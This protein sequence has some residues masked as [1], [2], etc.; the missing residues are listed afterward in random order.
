MHRFLEEILARRRVRI[1]EFRRSVTEPWDE[2]GAGASPPENPAASLR[3]G[4]GLIVAEVKRASPSRGPI[5]PEAD[6][7]ERARAYER[8]GAGA[9]SILCEPDFFGGSRRDVQLASAAVAV[10]VLCKDFILD[11][12][13]LRMARA[14]GARW[15]LLIARILGPDVPAMIREALATGLEPLVEVHSEREM[16][17]AAQAGA[18]LLGMNARDL[19]TFEVNLDLVK[20]LA[21]LCPPDRACIAESGIGG[22]ED[23]LDLRAAGAHGFLIG[24]TFMRLPDPVPLL[25]QFRLALDERAAGARP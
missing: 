3:A 12:I 6:A 24:E 25:R 22:V 16:A 7:A 8:G 4:T 20:T 23:L 9:V 21:R 2:P 17:D 13:Q 19:D 14:D 10:P 18:R 11:P 1:D 5:A 15:V